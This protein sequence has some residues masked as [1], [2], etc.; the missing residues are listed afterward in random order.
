[1]RAFPANSP[2][3]AGR[4]LALLLIAD[5]NVCA[6]EIGTLTR[7]GAEPRLGLPEGGLSLLLRDLCEDLLMVSAQAGPL[8][9]QVDG[10]TLRSLM[11]EVT[12]PDLR[13]AVLTLAHAAAQAD[14]HLAEGEAF[15]LAAA[16]RYWSLEPERRMAT[17]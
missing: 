12:D 7:L 6:S 10:A 14:G 13:D 9:E 1:M 17:A 16:C 5:G 2:Q 4:V 11:A 8:I 3:A 15:V